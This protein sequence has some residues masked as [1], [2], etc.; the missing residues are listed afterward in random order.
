M[1]LSEII[2]NDKYRDETELIFF[3]GTCTKHLIS[4]TK[5]GVRIP[6]T[7]KIKDFGQGFYLTSRYWQ[8]REYANKMAKGSRTSPLIISC[9]IQLG[10]LRNTNRKLIIDDF[11]EEWLETIIRGRFTPINPLKNHFDWVYGRCGDNNTPVFEEHY[12]KNDTNS[13]LK[14]LL[15]HIIPNKRFPHYEY[16]QLWL[17]TNK[18]IKCIQSVEFISKEGLNY[19]PIPIL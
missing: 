17:G 3:H 6:N 15:P 4:F 10:S 8:A 12:R 18:A 9:V 7:N 5:N 11:N 14:T 16:D 1:R 13:D 19:D 2:F